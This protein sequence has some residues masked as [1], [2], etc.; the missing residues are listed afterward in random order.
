MGNAMSVDVTIKAIDDTKQA[1]D[2]ATGNFQK[3]GKATDQ[4]S[5]NTAKTADDFTRLGGDFRKLR[6]G[7]DDY[8]GQLK[9]ATPQNLKFMQEISKIG[10]AFEDGSMS[11]KDAAKALEGV[12]SQMDAARPASEK[13]AAGFSKFGSIATKVVG[14]V[15]AEIMIM[16]KIMDFGAEGAQIEYVEQKFDRLAKSIGTTGDA[17]KGDLKAAL[18]GTLSDAEMMSGASDLMALGLANSSQEAVRLATVVGGLNMPM[19]Q[20]VLAL[21]N[22]TTMRFDQLGV[23]V[24]GFQEKVD[25]L[26]KSGMDA[27]AAFREAFLQQAEEQLRLVGNAADTDVGSFKRLD[28]ATQNLGDSIKRKL[29]PFLADAA[30]AAYL[31]L[32]YTDRLN[33]CRS[34]ARRRREQIF[35]AL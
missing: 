8:I 4:L 16:K 29:A 11:A 1:V 15:V 22:M 26:K 6:P 33:A 7:L 23:R 2:S 21:T 19:N 27:T 18:K 5:A 35:Q 20:L 34:Q 17:L 9:A 12:R 14:G 25:A 13:L 32:T 31:L 28:A 24:E 30:E 10:S 3:L